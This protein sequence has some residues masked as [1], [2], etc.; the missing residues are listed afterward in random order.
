MFHAH[1]MTSIE[2]RHQQEADNLNPKS[3]IYLGLLNR[4]MPRDSYYRQQSELAATTPDAPPIT[5]TQTPPVESDSATQ[6]REAKL[7]QN[8]HGISE[9]LRKRRRT[10]LTSSVHSSTRV[11]VDRLKRS[12]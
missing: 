7:E 6:A 10:N 3:N 5:T 4:K 8:R 2:V 11:L 12:S 1:F 9:K